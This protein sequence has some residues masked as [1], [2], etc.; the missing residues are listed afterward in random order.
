MSFI[1][2]ISRSVVLYCT[3][4]VNQPQLNLMTSLFLPITHACT[5]QANV[6]ATNFIDLII[7][8]QE[9]DT[10]VKISPYECSYGFRSSKFLREVLDMTMAIIPVSTSSPAYGTKK[11]WS[12]TTSAAG[13]RVIKSSTNN[14]N[15]FDF[16]IVI[17]DS[18]FH[19]IMAIL[20]YVH[21][22]SDGIDFRAVSAVK[23]AKTAQYLMIESLHDLLVL[24]SYKTI[25]GKP[26]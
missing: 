7:R 4:V 21:K 26:N 13:N 12:L 18:N 10:Y 9:K 20:E 14:I 23:Y 11:H 15:Q 8:S 19:D 17:E 24:W 16:P 25:T 2:P 3:M 6:M 5:L 22:G 1:P